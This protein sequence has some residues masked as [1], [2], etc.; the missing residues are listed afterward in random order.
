[1]QKKTTNKF[2]TQGICFK[3]N[4]FALRKIYFLM[5]FIDTGI[6]QG[7]S[8]TIDGLFELLTLLQK[9][10]QNKRQIILLVNNKMKLLNF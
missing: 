10:L 8:R 3:S 9:I 6:F 4:N 5:E 2:V 1:L 7:K